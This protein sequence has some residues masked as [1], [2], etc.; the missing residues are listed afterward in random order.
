MTKLIVG[1][2]YLGRRVAGRWRAAGHEV[3]GVVRHEAQL[4]Q[5]ADQRVRGI[6]ADVTRPETL[7]DLPE[8]ETVLFCVGWDPTGGATRRQVYVD[9]LQAVLDR[10]APATGRV[11]LISSTGVYGAAAGQWVDEASPCRPTR[12]A[13][14]ALLAAEEL[15]AAHP[16]GRRGIVLRLAG[17][18]GPGRLPQ[19]DAIRAG[20]PIAVAS[21]RSV[22]LIHVD[23]AAA[24]VLAAESLARPPRTYVV[25][26][27]RPVDRRTYLARLAD[28]LKFPPPTFSDEDGATASQR[29]DSGDKRLCN[30]RMLGEL[31]VRLAYPSFW[32]GLA[33]AADGS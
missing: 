13:G 21:G 27:G 2:G 7:R 17:L 14:R 8:A 16:L 12:D 5:L 20:L 11:I 24:V 1:C 23:D 18:Y 26:D 28:V 4:R 29:R 32:E 10:L 33:Q 25:A 22:N 9:G 3:W 15:L 31:G 19:T 6:V 30:A